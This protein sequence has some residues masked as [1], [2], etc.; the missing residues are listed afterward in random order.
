MNAHDGAMIY[1]FINKEQHM[2]GVCFDYYLFIRLNT[3][4]MISFLDSSNDERFLCNYM[5]VCSVKKM[6]WI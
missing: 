4:P 6:S 1:L 2:W 5:K 3:N